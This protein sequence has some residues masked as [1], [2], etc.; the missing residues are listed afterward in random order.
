MPLPS[1]SS[2]LPAL[3]FLYEAK[4]LVKFSAAAGKENNDKE[5]SLRRLLQPRKEGCARNLFDVT[6]KNAFTI[7]RHGPTLLSQHL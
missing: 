7:D 5:I 6:I 3:A 2:W 4:Q 1:P